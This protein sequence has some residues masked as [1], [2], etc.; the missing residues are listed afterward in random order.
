MFNHLDFTKYFI[1]IWLRRLPYIL[2][3][4]RLRFRNTVSLVN[5]LRLGMVKFIWPV[6]T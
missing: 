6:G 1:I 4:F 5:W 3:Q 2:L